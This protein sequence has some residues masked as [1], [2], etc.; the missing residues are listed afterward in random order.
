MSIEKIIYDL[1]SLD[2]LNASISDIYYKKK[3]FVNGKDL[4]YL[5][6]LLSANLVKIERVFRYVYFSDISLESDR[7]D[8]R[9]FRE[10]FP[11]LFKSFANKDYSIYNDDGS[12]KIVDGITYYTWML[13]RFRNINLHAIISTPLSYTMRID[14]SFIQ[15]F[16]KIADSICYVKD[17][18]LTIS[19]MLIMVLAA[20]SSNDS[21][22]FLSNFVNVWGKSI[23][24]NIGNDGVNEYKKT[25]ELIFADML[26]NNY[27]VDIREKNNDK[28]I[29]D[30][31]FGRIYTDVQITKINENILR[32]CLDLS[33]CVKAP[34]FC[35]SGQIEM[36]ADKCILMVD[37]GSNIGEYFI[38]DYT[39]KIY[40]IQAFIETCQSA[41]PFLG[42]VYLYHNNITELKDI[43]DV[44]I[45][46]LSK[47]NKPKFY[48]DKNIMILCCGANFADMREINKS[49]SEG[50]QKA[51]L[52]IEEKLVFELGIPVYNT[53]SKLS[54][55]LKELNVPLELTSRLI[56]LRNFAAHYGMLNDYYF[57][58][59]E[60]GYYIDLPFIF[61]VFNDL[62][63]YLD[64]IG[65]HNYANYVRKQYFLHIINNLIG[66]KYK[67]IFLKSIL[68][69][70]RYGDKVAESCFDIN[71]SLNT[72][73]YSIIDSETERL[74]VSF[75]P[76]R[77]NFIIPPKVYRFTDNKF[78]F[79]RLTLIKIQGKDLS[80]SDVPLGRDELVFLKT[81]ATDFSK[82]KSNG[83]IVDFDLMDT[84][85]EGVLTIQTYKAKEQSV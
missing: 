58:N 4:F 21:K 41:P 83:K 63:I 74:I 22:A 64:S 81:P 77:F 73:K 49:A 7:I 45:E 19:G 31:I 8:Q 70:H 37:K 69:F 3:H 62:I 82:I 75:S 66:V 26:R 34:R 16:P 67:R 65:N 85:D 38:N 28:N 1:E 40:N 10:Q 72:A 78:Y 57:Y 11:F 50:V 47:L 25:L 48:R 12:Q 15:A 56:V 46:R 43:S 54:V 32:F 52:D 76:Y 20:L 53:Y 27:E 30:S 18:E 68:L 23:C 29:L 55:I 17:G 79:N 39:L 42:L 33:Q 44:D 9:L 13:K 2:F 35:V 24:G 59:Q 80:V 71:Q 84:Y 5:K 6:G 14:E 60:T 61:S 36:T 51:L